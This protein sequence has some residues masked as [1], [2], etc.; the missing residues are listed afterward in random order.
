[1]IDCERFAQNAQDK[2]ATASEWLRSLRGNER[3]EQITHFAQ[4]KWATMSDLLSL[5]RGNE[6]MSWK[7]LKSC[8]T[9]FYLSWKFFW[10]NERI[11]LFRSFPLFWWAMWVNCSF[12]SNQMSDVSELLILLTKNEQMS[13][14]LIF[15]I[16]SLIRSKIK[17][18]NS[19]PCSL[20]IGAMQNEI[21]KSVAGS[22]RGS[23]DHYIFGS[24]EM[25]RDELCMG[26]VCGGGGWNGEDPTNG[27]QPSASWPHPK[28]GQK[29]REG[30]GGSRLFKCFRLAD[31][32]H[33]WFLILVS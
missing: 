17:W 22:G 1:M 6:G 20:L 24:A 9:M 21:V 32:G 19:Q 15:L 13:E 12:R 7:N 28:H 33:T 3:C 18:A 27:V 30:G 8:F 4:N 5:L 23:C 11:A 29:L 14:S 26:Y 31:F 25:G 10:K 16:E 2:W